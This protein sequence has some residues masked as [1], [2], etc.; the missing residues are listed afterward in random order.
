PVRY[1]VGAAPAAL[2]F[3]DLDGDGSGELVTVNQG[4]GGGSPSSLSILGRT[5]G[6]TVTNC[7]G[8]RTQPAPLPPRGLAAL[9]VDGDG[10]ADLLVADEQDDSL[11]WL[12]N[13]GGLH[14]D[15]GEGTRISLLAAP[16]ALL[17]ADFDGDGREDVLVL[18]GQSALLSLLRGSRD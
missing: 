13:Q 14:F 9:D 8:G 5:G 11:R 17:T 10:R 1:P 3:Q 6:G 18:H 2:L 15:C 7:G 4:S 12:R 16:L